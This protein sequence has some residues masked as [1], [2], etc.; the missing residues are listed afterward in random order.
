MSY[1]IPKGC[2]FLFCL[3]SSSFFSSS[4]SFPAI[5][6]VY[7]VFLWPVFYHLLIIEGLTFGQDCAF[8]QT[9]LLRGIS[10]LF[11]YTLFIYILI[12]YLLPFNQL[13]GILLRWPRKRYF[14]Y[15]KLSSIW[16][17]TLLPE[18]GIGRMSRVLTI[19]CFLGKTV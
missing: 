8:F 3:H 19:P 16:W 12:Y 18:M 17:T 2:S 1:W 11:F 6:F 13:Q 10:F 4:S 9:T 7:F 5:I 14:Y 15:T